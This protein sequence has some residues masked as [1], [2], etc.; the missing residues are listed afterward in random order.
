[1]VE[2]G[3]EAAVAVPWSGAGGIKKDSCQNNTGEV[4]IDRRLSYSGRNKR[5][6]WT[7]AT[8]DHTAARR[9]FHLFGCFVSNRD[10]FVLLRLLRICDRP[11][12]LSDIKVFSFL[13][14]VPV[15]LQSCSSSRFPTVAPEFT[16]I[17]RLPVSSTLPAVPGSLAVCFHESS[18][19]RGRWSETPEA[20]RAETSLRRFGR[21]TGTSRGPAGTAA[22]GPGSCVGGGAGG[23]SGARADSVSAPGGSAGVG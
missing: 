7:E 3:V 19:D 4:F 5:P 15:S 1:M 8:C 20:G 12:L 9:S 17:P 6:I 14:H 13:C 2:A 18:C 16:A 11:P 22:A 21:D 10:G 23:A